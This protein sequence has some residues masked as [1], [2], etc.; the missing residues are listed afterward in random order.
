MN[1]HGG[2]YEWAGTAEAAQIPSSAGVLEYYPLMND[3]AMLTLDS[4]TEENL[5][6]SSKYPEA[7][8]HLLFFDEDGEGFSEH[9]I[10]IG[11]ESPYIYRNL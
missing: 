5:L 4:D 6:Y 1:D 8:V 3:F 11:E 2:I 10:Y 7:V 9:Q